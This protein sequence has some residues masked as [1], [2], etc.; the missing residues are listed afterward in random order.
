MEPL[1]RRSGSGAELESLLRLAAARVD[2]ARGDPRC[3]SIAG[4]FNLAE[5]DGSTLRGDI[6][7]VLVHL[8]L[9][10]RSGR[11]NYGPSRPI[12]NSYF[13]VFWQRVQ[14]SWFRTEVGVSPKAN[15]L[16][17]A[18]RHARSRTRS[19]SGYVQRS[20]ACV[21]CQRCTPSLPARRWP[22]FDSAPLDVTLDLTMAIVTH[23]AASVL[24]TR[25]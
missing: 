19:S 22:G 23:D 10:R 18:H 2:V 21:S 4:Q 5:H 6:D 8:C 3:G 15:N 16:G 13:Q 24:V 1:A 25:W 11:A 17:A 7:A 20:L 12:P 9:D 14:L